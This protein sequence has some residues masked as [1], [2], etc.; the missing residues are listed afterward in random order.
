M[1]S[2]N[3]QIYQTLISTIPNVELKG[4]KMP[5]T[6]FNGHMFSF[7][8][9]DGNLGLRLPMK[10][11]NEFIIEHKTKLCEAHGTI[12]KEYVLV[13]EKLFLNTEMIKE[14]FIISF[15]YVSS[16]SPKPTKKRKYIN[17]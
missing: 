14:Y 17:Q 8:D 5:Y 1:F 15:A 12:L 11:R 7:L 16:L 13:P 6:S 10:E 3:V 2:D 4:A 9:K